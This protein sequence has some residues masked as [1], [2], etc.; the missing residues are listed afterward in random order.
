MV[1]SSVNQDC[2][3]NGAKGCH[4]TDGV[5]CTAVRSWCLA[6]PSA[7]H[8]S[9]GSAELKL[10]YKL[11]EATEVGTSAIKFPYSSVARMNSIDQ[12]KVVIV[13]LQHTLPFFPD[14]AGCSQTVPAPLF[15]VLW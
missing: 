4:L 9:G 5:P 10:S 2:R 15:S 13:T 14:P 3:N 7:I 1:L 8:Q 11:L 12:K 6:L